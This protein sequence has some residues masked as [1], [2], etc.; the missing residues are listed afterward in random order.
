[1]LRI[2]KKPISQRFQLFSQ[3]LD[4]GGSLRQRFVPPW[5]SHV[6]RLREAKC[7]G[8]GRA[9]RGSRLT[10]P[11]RRTIKTLSPSVYFKQ[12]LSIDYRKQ[13]LFSSVPTGVFAS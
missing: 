12:K 3:K 2:A 8:K 6:R 9:R 11:S 5:D 10:F 7:R 1:M 13:P 4:T